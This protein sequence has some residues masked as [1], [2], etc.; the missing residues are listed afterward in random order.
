[1]LLGDILK[2]IGKS[3]QA[4]HVDI[5]TIPD[6]LDLIASQGKMI[7]KGVAESSAKVALWSLP[8]TL[9]GGKFGDEVV[10]RIAQHVRRFSKYPTDRFKISISKIRLENWCTTGASL[11]SRKELLVARGLNLTLSCLITF[12]SDFEAILPIS[13]TAHLITGCSR[14]VKVG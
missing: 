1:M 2:S 12:V 3:E 7:D 8:S 5:F 13:S 11:G 9:F 4:D 10:S 6:V 14:L